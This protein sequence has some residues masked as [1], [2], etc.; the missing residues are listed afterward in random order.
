M[1]LS[2]EEALRKI[3]E[4]EEYI[5]KKDCN[6][7]N[8]TNYAQVCAELGESSQSCPYKRIKQIE[9]FFGQGWRPNWS[10]QN[11]YKYYPYFSFG[12]GGG[13]VYYHYHGCGSYFAG[14]VAF[15]KSKEIAIHV[16]KYFLKEYQEFR[17]SY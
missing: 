10:N 17:D 2:K 9:R 5:N 15:Y 4:L 3:K 16:G 13:L 7:F 14:E 6:I 8:I 11:E 12:S 1:N